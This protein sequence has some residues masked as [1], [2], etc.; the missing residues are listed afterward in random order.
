MIII[1]HVVF[2]IFI[3][4]SM[5]NVYAAFWKNAAVKS[6]ETFERYLPSFLIWPKNLKLFTIMYKGTTI[7]VLLFFTSI[8]VLFILG[9]LN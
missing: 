2:I 7:F 8:Y 5:Y 1:I 3:I 9:K 6:K 4:F